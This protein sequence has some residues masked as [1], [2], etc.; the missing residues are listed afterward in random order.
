MPSTSTLPAG[1]EN[2]L[3]AVFGASYTEYPAEY[4]DCL[5]V[6]TSNSNFERYQQ[7][8]GLG[9]WSFKGEGADVDYD[10]VVQGPQTALRNVTYGLGVTIT[11]EMLEDG[12]YREMMDMMKA[13][14]RGG[15]ETV[16]TVA[17]SIYNNSDT[18]GYTGADGVV[19]GS[20]SHPTYKSSSTFSNYDSGATPLTYTAL[21]NAIVA[22]GDIIDDAGNLCN[23]T[24]GA[25]TLVVPPELEQ[26]AAQI[27]EA[28]HHEAVTET[29]TMT[30]RFGNILRKSGRNIAY[31]VNHY[32]T[33]A[34]D[35]YLFFK[36]VPSG[37]MFQ[38]RVRPQFKRDENFAQGAKFKGRQR[39]AVGWADPR[40]IYITV[41]S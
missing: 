32:I 41:G 28:I 33:D 9:K 21:W 20:A 27:T 22:A 14:G 24:Q 12:K 18:A 30:H 2:N 34:D 36:D 7:I 11:E 26:V 3:R 1:L 25:I 16:E 31:K 13:L 38:W 29:A 23:L 6:V 17:A 40:A 35:W 4:S 10:D 19:L 8:S 5:N 37:L 15:R 39:F